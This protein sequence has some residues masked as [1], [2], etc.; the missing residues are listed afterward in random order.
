M[1][2]DNTSINILVGE[3]SL[4]H[5]FRL[6]YKTAERGKAWQQVAEAMQRKGYKVD[7]R[8]VR[9]RISLL[10][11]QVKVKKNLKK[12]VG[13]VTVEETKGEKAIREA[14]EEMI[15]EEEDM[16]M[17]PKERV[18]EQ[19]VKEGDGKESRKR[20]CETFAETRKRYFLEEF[21]SLTNSW[22]TP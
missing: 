5:P 1:T 18:D 10:K 2:W 19:K 3:V 4:A 9:D 17:A 11:E 21:F 8:A 7:S 14:V 6:K 15:Q 16:E 20:A 12:A 13:G 22:C